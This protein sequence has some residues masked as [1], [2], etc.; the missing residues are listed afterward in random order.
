MQSIAVRGA[1]DLLASLVSELPFDTYAPVPGGDRKR[2]RATPGYMQDPGGD[3]N[4]VEDWRYQVMVSWLT[5]GNMFGEALEFDP[6]GIYPTQIDVW[7]PDSVSGWS[8]SDGQDHWQHNG[9]EVT[10]LRRFVHRRVNPMPGE[11]L[12]LSPI[13]QHADSIGQSIASSRFGLQWFKDGAHPSGILSNEEV[14]MTPDLIS[15]AK[16]RFLA[17]VFGS[18]E[19]L[20]LGKGWKY[21]AI[22]VSAEESQFLAT[23]GFSEAQCARMFGPGVAEALGYESGGSLTYATVESRA[24]DLLT[25]T[26]NRWLRRMDRFQSSMLPSPWVIETDRDA[27]L[28]STTLDKYKAY[29]QALVDGWRTINEIRTEDENKDPVAWGNEPFAINAV[30]SDKTTEDDPDAPPKEGDNA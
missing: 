3:G 12:G 16:E 8:D 6:R 10:D 2:K 23:M 30:A 4:G 21:S 14:E 7:N 26:V 19:P 5:R 18:R 11:A 1:I 13:R 9:R 24:R 17:A 27:L 15:T 25:Y 28:Q 20:V 22:Q 29:H